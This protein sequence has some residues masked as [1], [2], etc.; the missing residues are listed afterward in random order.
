MRNYAST[1]NPPLLFKPLPPSLGSKFSG[2]QLCTSNLSE[3]AGMGIEKV[4]C[5]FVGGINEF[6]LHGA[7]L[8]LLVISEDILSI[9]TPRQLE[10]GAAHEIAHAKLGHALNPVM[11]RS[12][13]PAKW[14]AV[15]ASA[16]YG[17]P[18]GKTQLP[19]LAVLHPAVLLYFHRLRAREYKADSEAALL[20]GN[21]EPLISCLQE[22]SQYQP[23]ASGIKRLLQT[24]PPASNRI[25]RLGR[26][27]ATPDAGEGRKL[28]VL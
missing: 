19:K 15:I 22:L 18:D 8:P 28:P 3:K 27:K 6:R 17:A 14:R 9:L 4:E 20:L 5:R 16:E 26:L 21:P 7:F 12:S 24:H 2:L 10:G 1:Q 11:L 25:R 13:I 23:T